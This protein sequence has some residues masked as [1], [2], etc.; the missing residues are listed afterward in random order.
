M[1]SVYRVPGT[2]ETRYILGFTGRIYTNNLAIETRKLKKYSISQIKQVINKI[3]ETKYEI[4]I[5]NDQNINFLK[6]NNNNHALN[7][8][9]TLMSLEVLP[10]ITKPTRTT[11]STATLIDNTCLSKNLTRDIQSRILVEDI[12]DHLPCIV[13]INRGGRIYTNNLTLE[14]RKVNKNS[15]DKVRIDLNQTN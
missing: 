13:C 7:I 2:S 4:V 9:N 3:Q 15:I 6:I 14:T 1:G 5:G 11:H 12:S 8:R 10:I